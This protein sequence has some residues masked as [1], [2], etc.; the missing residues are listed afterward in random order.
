MQP[1]NIEM[2][3]VGGTPLSILDNNPLISWL[4]PVPVKWLLRGIGGR[5]PIGR[6]MTAGM[7]T[8]S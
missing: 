1:F 6:T 4:I 7:C 2:L 8:G 3:P 5:R